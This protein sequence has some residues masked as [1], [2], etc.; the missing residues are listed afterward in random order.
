[1]AYEVYYQNEYKRWELNKSEFLRLCQAVATQMN[2][3]KFVQGEGEKH[4]IIKD[5]YRLYLK[6]ETSP[7]NTERKTPKLIISICGDIVEAKGRHHRGRRVDIYNMLSDRQ[8]EA[9]STSIQVSIN[10]GAYTIAKE[11]NRRL[12][13]HYKELYQKAH[14]VWEK[15]TNFHNA[16][17][18]LTRSIAAIIDGKNHHGNE[19]CSIYEYVDLGKERSVTVD[20]TIGSTDHDLKLRNVPTDLLKDIFEAINKH[21]KQSCY[22]KWLDSIQSTV[23]YQLNKKLELKD[24]DDEILELPPLDFDW[25]KVYYDQISDWVIADRFIQQYLALQPVAV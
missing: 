15:S 4:A 11:I 5:K 22:Q 21:S 19:G 7:N 25:R 3:W 1:M 20:V 8:R 9:Y 17:L 12:M 14:D 10:R 23:L 16:Q 6:I 24:T 2:N 13:P 18:E